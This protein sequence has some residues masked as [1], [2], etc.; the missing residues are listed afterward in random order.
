MSTPQKSSDSRDAIVE[1]PPLSEEILEDLRAHKPAAVQRFVELYLP[2]IYHLAYRMCRQLDLARDAA[3]EALTIALQKV[4]QFRGESRL[5]TWLYQILFRECLRSRRESTRWATMVS[6]DERPDLAALSKFTLSPGPEEQ[7]L[8]DEER[9]LF[10][11]AVERLPESLRSVYLLREVEGLSTQ[12][13][14]R[15]LGLS[16]SNVKVRLHRA[17]QRLKNFLAKAVRP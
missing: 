12:E 17:R 15:V 1:S 7:S 14:A 5:I 2:R 11:E 8:R 9:R 10:W 3:Q 16:E 6:L 4:H 13:V